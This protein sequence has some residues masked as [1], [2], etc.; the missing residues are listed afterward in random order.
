MNV[1]L[2]V[3]AT[4]PV[5]ALGLGIYLTDRFDKEP[6]NLLVK[7]F[8]FGMLSAI[9]ISIIERILMSF[10][11]FGG[12][13]SIAYVAF[14]VA[15]LTE[16]FFKRQVVLR[17]AF[18]HEAFNE[19]LD[20]IVYCIY[21]ALGFALVENIIYVAFRFTTNPHIGIYRGLLSV[22]AHTL[23]AV[24]MGYYLSLSK[25]ADNK[26]EAREFMTKSLVVPII[27][28]GL[29]NFILM[30]NIPFLMPILIAFVVYLW[31]ISLRKLNS[32]YKES[33]HMYDSEF[34]KK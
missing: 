25:F 21:S 6:F 15:G 16:E 17:L 18:N 5:F 14:I 9:P 29:F 31:I 26:K 13:L 3:I 1:R 19:K 7:V 4:I 20:G 33:K 2:I 8:I 30:S 32:Y 22:P 34:L 28:H 11:I 24:T 10:D 27:F 23:F 12:F